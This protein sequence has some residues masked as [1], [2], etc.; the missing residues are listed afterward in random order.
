MAN[1]YET[2]ANL[3]L[4]LGI[5]PLDTSYDVLLNKALS[6]A[7]RGIDAKCGAPA[8]RFWLDAVASARTFNP[9]GRTASTADGE[10]FLVDDIG[11]E[12]GLVVEVGSGSTWIAIVAGDYET[13]PDNAMVNGRAIEGMLRVGG[14]WAADPRQRLRVTARWGWPAV[15]DVVVEATRIQA[16]RLF[17]RKDSP[18]GIL[19]SADWGGVAN[20]A[21]VDPDVQALIAHL[22]LPGIA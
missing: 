3:K 1:E 11:A 13:V 19:G 8:R 6:A 17:K 7:S 18:E 15:P 20:L 21:R 12:A 14:C 5:E 16:S 4:T 22:I 2:P 9:R 10:L